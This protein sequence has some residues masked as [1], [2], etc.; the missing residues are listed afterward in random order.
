MQH[1]SKDVNEFQ[2]VPIS[3]HFHQVV[4]ARTEGQVWEPKTGETTKQTEWVEGVCKVHWSIVMIWCQIR[5]RQ[6][7]CWIIFNNC[8]LMFFSSYCIHFI[9]TYATYCFLRVIVDT[10]ACIHTIL[11]FLNDIF[12]LY[13]LYIYIYIFCLCIFLIIYDIYDG[14]C[15]SYILFNIQYTINILYF[16]F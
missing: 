10:C 4:L 12:I 16:L 6:M 11:H 3:R 13:S 15:I 2:A 7:L 9:V 14:L 8:V 1:L 5:S